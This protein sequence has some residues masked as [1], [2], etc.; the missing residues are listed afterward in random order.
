MEQEP[1]PT[2]APTSSSEEKEA[3][4]LLSA[5]LL[6]LR[7]LSQRAVSVAGHLLPLIALALGFGLAWKIMDSP[8][9]YQLTGLAIYSAFALLMIWLRRK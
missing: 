4:V 1:S 3:S 2:P 6:G 7:I 8:N 9:P 5:T